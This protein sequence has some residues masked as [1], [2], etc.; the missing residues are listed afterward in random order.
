MFDIKLIRET[1]GTV[2]ENLGKRQEPEYLK[3]LDELI[4]KDTEWR[5][6][7]QEAD[8]LRARRNA[9]SKEINI[10]KKEGKD[11]K[12]LL[13]EAKSIPQKIKE[14]EEKSKELAEK[15]NWYLMRLPNLLKESV[16]F[17]KSDEDNVVEKEVGKKP[18]RNFEIKHHGQLAAE[19]DLADFERAVKISGAGFFY[20]KGDLALLDIALQRY[21]IDK[22]R[23]KGYTLI[24][25]PHLMRT[26]AYEGV[27]DLADFDTV[28]YKVDGEDMRMIATAEHP[29]AAM[30]KGE[31]L[32]EE[33]LPIKLCGVS[34][35]YRREIGKHGLDER[36]FFRV[37]QFNKV[38]Q[39]IFCAP[40][41]GEKYFE[42]IARNAEE[43]L[44]E[45]E[46]PYQR[47]NVCTGDLGIIAAKKYDL[48]G[49][50]PREDKFIEL[51]SC[52]NCTGYQARR[53][54]IRFRKKGS[55]DKEVV[56]TLNNTMIATTRF[57]RVLIENYQ[58]EK[59]TIEVPK[60]LRP[61]MD[62]LE[63]IPSK[64]AK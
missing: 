2:R 22:L 30:Y 46:I 62:G 4:E 11:A 5:S 26:D 3:W 23:K 31:I 54:G 58:T 55:T 59:G 45:L 38:E 37:H 43:L 29:M 47:T 56:H 41:D 24:Q 61:Y 20:L 53:L 28:M 50:S 16:P 6:L 27:V 1:P 49:Y 17:G 9:I 44:E 52:S 33:K 32:E 10:V 63:E 13:E 25:P 35:C 39:F 34:P 15:T 12:K 19:L 36:G 42:E 48:V 57:L 60:V 21:A 8:K 64:K 51:M 7:K 40:E 14:I 18:K